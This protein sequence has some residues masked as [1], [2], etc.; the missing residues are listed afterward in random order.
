M[1]MLVRRRVSKESVDYKLLESIFTLEAEWKQFQQI[2]DN[3]YD[4]DNIIEN[5]FM[6]HLKQA[7]YMFLLQEAK[8]RKVRAFRY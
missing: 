3:S 7:K 1:R 2:I 6:F 8:H 4:I 5:E